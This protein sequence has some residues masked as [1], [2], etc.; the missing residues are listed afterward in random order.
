MLDGLA[1]LKFFVQ[2]YPKDTLA[3]IKAHFSYYAALNKLNKKR[4]SLTQSNTMLKKYSI[5]WGYFLLGKKYY[6]QF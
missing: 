5:V 2:G 3:V 4:K 6:T 1:G